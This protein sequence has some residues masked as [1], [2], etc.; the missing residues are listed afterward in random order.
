MM[1]KSVNGDTFLFLD[2]ENNDEI[3]V[4]LYLPQNQNNIVGTQFRIGFDNTKLSFDKIEYSN[5]QIQNFQT[6][7]GDYIN[8][9]SVSTNGSNNLNNGIEYKIYFKP[10]TKMDSILGL[11]SL[12]KTE[13]IDS[14]GINLEIKVK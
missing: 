9:G 13:I 10:N 4:T 7:R 8:F 5:T 3:I 12:I 11:V 14:N 6:T 1:N 2:I